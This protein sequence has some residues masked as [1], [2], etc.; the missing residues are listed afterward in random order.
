MRKKYSIEKFQTIERLE[1]F[2]NANYESIVDYKVGAIDN[3]IFA[4]FEWKVPPEY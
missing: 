1:S 2:L 3:V 4:I